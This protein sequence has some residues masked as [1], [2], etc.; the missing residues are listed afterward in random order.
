MI[1]P[2]APSA[3]GTAVEGASASQLV[4]NEITAHLAESSECDGG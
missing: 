3:Y 2:K 4:R 1:N